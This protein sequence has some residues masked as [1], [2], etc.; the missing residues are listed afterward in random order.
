MV[1][2][3]INNTRHELNQLKI[4]VFSFYRAFNKRKVNEWKIINRVEK[5][6]Y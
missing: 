6:D 4:E 1:N 5:A 2:K 3:F